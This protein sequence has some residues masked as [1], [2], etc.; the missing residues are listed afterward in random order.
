MNDKPIFDAVRLLAGP[1][2]PVRFAAVKSA[3]LQM[4][5]LGNDRPLFEYYR[6]IDLDGRISQYE[7]EV[8]KRAV[9]AYQNNDQLTVVRSDSRD[10][11]DKALRSLADTEGFRAKAYP[12]PGSRDGTPWT[13]GYGSTGPDVRKGVVWTEPQAYARMVEDVRRFE[14]GVEKALDGAP[15]TQAQFDALV[16]FAYN[17]GIK[18]FANSTLLKLHKAGDYSGAA[19]QFGR[20]VKNDGRT[21]PGLVNR[22]RHESAMYQ[23]KV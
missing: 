18:A 22:R 17:T 20:W 15:T 16:H 3:L 23:G 14:D 5:S 4:G 2:S 12:D 6:T 9:A 11:S 10:M 21:M 7:F 13:V 8:L 1:I 19:I